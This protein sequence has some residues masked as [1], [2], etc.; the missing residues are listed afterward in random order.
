MIKQ[1]KNYFLVNKVAIP[2]NTFSVNYYNNK[3]IIL[4]IT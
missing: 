4:L 1:A 2:M 3:K